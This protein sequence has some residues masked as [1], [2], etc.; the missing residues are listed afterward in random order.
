MQ[1]DHPIFANGPI[2][3]CEQDF[4]SSYDSSAGIFNL[5]LVIQS[6][7]FSK[8]HH[9]NSDDWSKQSPSSRIA[10]RP[11]IISCAWFTKEA[12]DILVLPGM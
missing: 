12:V 2:F 4:C 11:N 7:R 5:D 8:N 10:F 3:C 6:R 9:H 1:L